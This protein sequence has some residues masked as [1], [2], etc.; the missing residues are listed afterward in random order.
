VPFDRRAGSALE[1][2]GSARI[3]LRRLPRDSL[4]DGRAGGI[5]TFARD[6]KTIPALR[7]CAHRAA[8][9]FPERSK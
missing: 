6:E 2:Y 8:C 1:Y 9:G 7:A 5:E 4:P 3:R